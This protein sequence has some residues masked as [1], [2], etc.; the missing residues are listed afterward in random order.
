[1]HKLIDVL[2]TDFA[3]T[4]RDFRRSPGVTLA[5]VA[6][7][8]LG[9][10]VNAGMFTVLDRILFQ[11]PDGVRRPAEVHRLYKVGREWGGTI[12]YSDWFSAPDLDGLRSAA[13]GVA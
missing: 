6:T 2:R 13:G 11:Q 5:I 4:L 8:T 9:V 3:Q 1:M 7:L 10:G 12:Q